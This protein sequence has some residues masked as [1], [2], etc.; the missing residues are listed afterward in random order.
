[1][2]GAPTPRRRRRASRTASGCATPPRPR[3]NAPGRAAAT[4]TTPCGQSRRVPAAAARGALRTT[5]SCSCTPRRRRR[6]SRPRRR[7]QADANLLANGTMPDGAWPAFLVRCEMDRGVCGDIQEGTEYGGTL[8][9]LD[10]AAHPRSTATTCSASGAIPTIKRPKSTR[11]RFRRA[12]P[13]RTRSGSAR[14]FPASAS[15]S[16]STAASH[17]TW[18]LRSTQNFEMLCRGKR[19]STGTIAL[20]MRGRMRGELDHQRPPESADVSVFI[21]YHELKDHPR[22]CSST[23]STWSARPR[24]RRRRSRPRRRSRCPRGTPTCSPTAR[25]PT[26]RGPPSWCAASRARACAEGRHHQRRHA[27]GARRRRAPGALRRPRVP[28]LAKR[29][30]H[31]PVCGHAAA[32]GANDGEE[33]QI[34]WVPVAPGERVRFAFHCRGENDTHTIDA[35]PMVRLQTANADQ[36]DQRNSGGET[37]CEYGTRKFYRTDWVENTLGEEAVRRR[38]RSCTTTTSAKVPCSST[39]CSWSTRPRRRRRRRLRRRRRSRPRR[40]SRTLG[41]EDLMGNGIDADGAWPAFLVRCDIGSNTCERAA[42][43]ERRRAAPRSLLEVLGDAAHALRRPACRFTPRATQMATHRTIRRHQASVDLYDAAWFDPVRPGER[44]KFKLHCMG[45]TAS[46]GIK[47]FIWLKD[48]SGEHEKSNPEHTCAHGTWTPAETPWVK[49]D[50]NADA[51]AVLIR[52]NAPRAAARCSSTAWRSHARSPRRPRR[53]PR[54]RRSRPRRRSRCPGAR[55]PAR[56]RHDARR[57]VARL[58]GALRSGH[59]RVRRG[60]HFARRH[61]RGARQRHLARALLRPRALGLGATPP[62]IPIT[63]TT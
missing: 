60:Q 35:R 49:N 18:R 6:R 33:G 14:C 41:F 52:Y 19:S 21:R 30:Q 16:G 45:E 43:T 2:P 39:A 48:A 57:R 15:V 22:R 62:T 24:R 13:T 37:C 27:R 34:D 32:L 46:I 20:P 8:E 63:S 17:P 23:A 28:L 44:V 38:C 61:A 36:K 31:L 58:P 50:F 42:G 3:P 29:A 40:R 1:M 26:A 54:H 7:S 10:D 56:Q 4:T 11:S 25:C 55:R 51:N 12:R 5:S 53:R 59:E 47:V 9:V